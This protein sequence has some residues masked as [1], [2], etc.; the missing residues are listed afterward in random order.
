[1]KEKSDDDEIPNYVTG[2]KTVIANQENS[3]NKRI[4]PNL[5]NNNQDKLS[6]NIKYSR[7]LKTLPILLINRTNLL[8]KY[9]FGGS[10]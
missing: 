5:T 3:S 4:I 6:N 9:L 7:L 1:M 8:T 10:L 2:L